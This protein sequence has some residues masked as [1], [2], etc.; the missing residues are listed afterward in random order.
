MG[1]KKTI[2]LRTIILFLMLFVTIPVFAINQ[3]YF[4]KLKKVVNLQEDEQLIVMYQ[5]IGSC[6]KCYLRPMQIIENLQKKGV[7]KK[8]KLLAL[9]KCDRDIE[10][11][12]YKRQHSWKYFMYRD[13]GDGY[14]RLN[15]KKR[16]SISIFNYKGM[17]IG[18]I[19]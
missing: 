19:K 1:V 2:L 9:V 10:L 7:V 11:K 3:N 13:D 14:K 8:F 6:V 4:N 17:K 15:A 12:I 16:T 18:D 5:D